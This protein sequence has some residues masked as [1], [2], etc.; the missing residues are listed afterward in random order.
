MSQF[1]ASAVVVRSLPTGG[2]ARPPTAAGYSPRGRR[3][4]RPGDDDTQPFLPQDQTMITIATLADPGWN[5]GRGWDGPPWPAFIL[6]SLFVATFVILTVLAY[7][8]RR[9][10]G[11]AIVGE[12]YARG[13]I[14]ENEYRRRLAELRGKGRG[15][16]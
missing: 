16:G 9:P 6:F 12:R 3:K 2:G 4:S 11:V 1:G 15:A 13:E 14:D 10:P 8:G 7:R 5:D